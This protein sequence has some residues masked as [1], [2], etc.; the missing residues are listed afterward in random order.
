MTEILKD[1]PGM[2]VY[3][4]DTL[5]H[6]KTKEEHKD[7]VDRVHKK[8]KE[9]GLKLNT[10]KCEYFKSEISFLGH[11]ISKDG[12]RP[13]PEKVSAITEM[14]EP[15][16]V[17]ELRRFLGLVNFL[18]KYV[19][20]LSHTL[21]PMT[22]LLEKDRAW[23][24]GPS[25][26]DA[27]KRV[28]ELITSAPTLAFFDANKPTIVSADASA[29]GL[30]AVLLQ[31]HDGVLKSVAYASR[32]LTSAETRYAQIEKECLASVWAC[33]RFERYLVGLDHFVLET[34]HKPLVPLINNKDIAECPIR[35]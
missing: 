29:Y 15:T 28:K 24:W 3:F 26:A 35:C 2:I 27:F 25:Q 33:G 30:G 18:G 1:I 8:L 32:T 14:E 34:D 20:H 11:L 16:N 13:H 21:K 4:D 12:C 9:V 23:I 7:L 31:D 10:E 6:S 19:P 5:L 22:E 17:A